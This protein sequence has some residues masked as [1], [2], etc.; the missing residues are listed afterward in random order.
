MHPQVVARGR[1]RCGVTG[2]LI[3][4]VIC[5]IKVAQPGTS[6]MLRSRSLSAV[7]LA[8]SCLAVAGAAPT[9]AEEPITLTLK[10]HRFVPNEV[11]APAGERFRIVVRNEDD[12]PS[13]FESNDL[14]VEKIVTPGG[15]ISVTAGP[16]KPGRYTFFDD[17]H[18]DTATGTLTVTEKKS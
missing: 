2:L 16:L 12:T 7:A 8:A 4:R 11:S 1:L 6:P 13:E 18:Q 10:G 9:R 15:T 17:Y 14:R 5:I 3:L